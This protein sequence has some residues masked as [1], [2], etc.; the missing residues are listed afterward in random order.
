MN[1][2]MASITKH[3]LMNEKLDDKPTDWSSS[4]CFWQLLWWH[5][6]HHQHQD[7]EQKWQA[8][9]WGRWLVCALSD[10]EVNNTAEWCLSCF[11]LTVRLQGRQ[12]AGNT[13]ISATHLI[14]LNCDD[15]SC[16]VQWLHLLLSAMSYCSLLWIRI[17]LFLKWQY[18]C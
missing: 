12:L 2:K 8:Y 15:C 1:E 3:H 18:F 9:S 5:S 17:Q 11:C 4:C 16:E 7:G 10:T 14:S 13:N 6:V